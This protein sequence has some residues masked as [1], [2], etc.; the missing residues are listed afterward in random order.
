MSIWSDAAGTVL[1]YFRLGIAGPRLKDSSGSLLV[2]N[3][4]DSADAVV[5]P[6]SLGT[7]TRDGTKFL[8]DDGAWT[9]AGGSGAVNNV[10]ST[11]TTVAG[12]TSYVVVDYLDVQSDFTVAGNVGVI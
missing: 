7:G 12:D 11:P 10:I 8:R 3:P 9:A 4:A 2:R 1:G 6:Q 5:L